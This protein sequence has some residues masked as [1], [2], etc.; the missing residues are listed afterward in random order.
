MEH[1]E[2]KTKEVVTAKLAP[3][4]KQAVEKLAANDDRTVSYM[5][6]RLLKDHPLVR[7]ELSRSDSIA[8]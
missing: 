8:A 2:Q 3:E 7:A 6:E 4:V 1:V 5:V